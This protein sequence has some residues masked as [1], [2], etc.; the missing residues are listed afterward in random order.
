MCT[1][2]DSPAILMGRIFDDRGNRMTPSH[3]NKAGVRYRYYVSHALLQRRKDEAGGV[4]RVPAAQVEATVVEAV[5][6]SLRKNAPT[7]GHS[8]VSDREAIDRFVE[9]IVI[10][11]KS[12]EIHLREPRAVEATETN[13]SSAAPHARDSDEDTAIAPAPVITVP[14][15]APAFVS[16]KG[17]LHQPSGKAMLKPETRDAILL[18]IVK[19]RTWIDDLVSGRVQSF[20]EIAQHEGKVERHVRLLAPLAF[21]PPGMLAAIIAGAAPS[22]LTVTALAQTI[23]NAWE[24]SA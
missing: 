14:W 5:R 6:Q 20:A 7:E 17:V 15:N 24:R 18:A 4:A 11:P 2:A 12:I 22:D 23:P 21:T 13:R 9:R 1:F 8:D 19:A 3:S 10:S 16:V